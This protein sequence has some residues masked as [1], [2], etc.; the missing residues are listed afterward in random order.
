MK[1]SAR[2]ILGGE[3]VMAIISVPYVANA[4]MDG[5]NIV[6]LNVKT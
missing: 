6:L 2:N 4:A 1:E 3:I 5:E